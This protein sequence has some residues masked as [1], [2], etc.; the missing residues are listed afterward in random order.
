MMWSMLA[1]FQYLTRSRECGW[2][3]CQCLLL[4][5]VWMTTLA[6]AA[7]ERKEE[8]YRCLPPGHHF[9]LVAIKTMG[10]V[11][12]KY[13]VLLWDV[14]R[15]IT[16]ETGEVRVR[17]FL[18]QQLSVAVQRGNCVSM[19]GTITTWLFFICLVFVFLFIFL[20]PCFLFLYISV[21][22]LYELLNHMKKF[23]L[24]RKYSLH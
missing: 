16:E 2:G 7:E 5:S 24:I 6:A 8:K 20:C 12:P 17:D 22:D 21:C 15:R 4:G 18:F 13:M 23:Y 10:A 11:G 14:G 19:L 1:C 3:L 9:S